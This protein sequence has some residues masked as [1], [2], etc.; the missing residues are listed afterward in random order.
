MTIFTEIFDF[1]LPRICPSC[2]NKLT[3]EEKFICTECLSK[4]QYMSADRM[5]SFYNNR[6]ANRRNISGLA[7]L[8]PFEKEKE[9]QRI[10]HA[11]KYKQKFLLGKYLGEKLGEHFSKLILDWQINLILPVPLHHL[12]KAERGYNQ[13]LVIVKGMYKVLRIEYKENILKRERFTQS[14][15][16][17]NQ[18][19]RE[20]NVCGAFTVKHPLAIKGGKILIVDDVI[21]TGAT[22][23][24]CAKVLLNNGAS[25]IYAA[26]AAIVD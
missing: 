10:I 9:L 4:I 22:I 15:T 25:K 13:S 5:Q 8:Y 16:H 2:S 7:A 24:E 17:L 12:K 6:F 19:E 3:I 20:E 11:L 21:T 1:L 14:Q 23:N 18:G 26:C